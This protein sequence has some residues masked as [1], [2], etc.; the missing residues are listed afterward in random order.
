[1]KMIAEANEWLF[2]VNEQIFT[3]HHICFGVKKFL[4]KKLLINP[5]F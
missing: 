2:V 5:H 3:L 4:L 1:M